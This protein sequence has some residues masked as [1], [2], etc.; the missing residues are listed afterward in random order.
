MD[1][2]PGNALKWI[3]PPSICLCQKSANISFLCDNVPINVPTCQR[4]TSF[5]IWRANVSETFQFL[6]LACQCAVRRANYFSK[7]YIF[8]YQLWFFNINFSIM[9]NIC[10]FQKCL[11]ISGKFIL[12]KKE[13][14]FLTFACFSL[15]VINLVSLTYHA[16]HKSCWKSIHHVSWLRNCFRNK[17]TPKYSHYKRKEP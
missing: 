2:A 16:Q 3:L 1:L 9:V 14:K 17:S 12:R 6:K 10:Q 11:S 7:K 13:F 4:R 8:Q 5:S 15:H